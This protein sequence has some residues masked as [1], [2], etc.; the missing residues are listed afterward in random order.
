MQRNKT[1]KQCNRLHS[2]GRQTGCASKKVDCGE[3][4]EEDTEIE[5]AEE[6]QHLSH[7]WR[8]IYGRLNG[9][10]ATEQYSL[11]LVLLFSLI[12]QN[13]ESAQ[14]KHHWKPAAE[15]LLSILENRR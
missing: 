2:H 3:G 5:T 8:P 7:V 11:L 6:E 4:E 1:N 10:I 12:Q 15:Q 14:L 9:Q 13:K